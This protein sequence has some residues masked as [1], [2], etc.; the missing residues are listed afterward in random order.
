M[1]KIIQLLSFFAAVSSLVV[2]QS[3]KEDD[4]LVPPTLSA[5]GTVASVQVGTKADVTFTFTA[6]EGY[7]SS[8]VTAVGGTATVKTPPASGATEGSVVVEFTADNTAGAASVTLDLIDAKD[9][10]I[11]QSATL[12]KTISAPPTV[13]LSATSGSANPGA[14]VKVTVTVTA[15]NGVKSLTYTTTGG[16]TGSPASPVTL[17]STT[18]ELTFTVP[19]AAA[20]GATYAVAITAVDNQNLNSTAATYTVTASTNELT[21]TITADVTLSKGVPYLVKS[22]YIIPTGK[23]LTVQAGAVV[24]GD[25][26]SKGVIIIQ[27]GGKLIAVGTATEPV[28]FTSSQPVGERD[29]GDWGGIVWLG[30]AY[31]N[32]S[33]KPSV[34]GI[35]PAQSY[36][37]VDPAQA[38]STVGV[39]DQDNGKLKYVRIEYAGIELTPNNETNSL[40]MGGLGSATEI[41]YVQTSYGGDDAFEWFG[42]TVN[43]KHLVSLST[44]DDD[45][46][47][48]FGW[49]GNVQW[50]IV[51]RNPFFADQSGST[52]F[53]SDSQA[54]G[55][56]IGTVCTDTEKGG[57]TRGV[58]SN[59][60]VLGPRDFT[61]SISGNYTRAMHIRRR[62]AISVH[63]S[64][65]SG[66]LSGLTI[67]D[68]GTL[69]NYKSDNTGEGRFTNNE[70]FVSLVP[71]TSSSTSTTAVTSI[72]AASGNVDFSVGTT[73]NANVESIWKAAGAGNNITKSYFVSRFTKDGAG[74]VNGQAISS[75]WSSSTST[76]A[77]ADVAFSTV[78]GWT[79]GTAVDIINPYSG[80]GL[81][82]STFFGSNTAAS[83]P[84]NPNFAVASGTITGKTAAT[85]FADAKLTNTFFTNTLTYIGAFGDTDWTDG[86]SEFQP[87]NKAY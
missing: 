31:V 1:K 64:V 82:T 32:Q 54:N 50:G 38:S 22:Q 39:N 29:R 75:T 77:G 3:C 25:K 69:T 37:T 70:L 84:S 43:A 11:S 46:D 53:E 86:W 24:K 83:Y 67:D 51:I 80:P 72:S 49:R 26:A 66:F 10:K 76:I 16:L 79:A 48:D 8:S 19:A 47:T 87:V 58:F 12:N 78:P 56:A 17:S 18:Q 85:L 7:A 33:A 15:P 44:W 41:D 59:I 45:F 34:E 30:D 28:V 40:T 14:T 36:G 73:F 62:T 21:G 5:P 4:P 23:T 57:C 6:A 52:A 2:I 61:R 63:N 65:I 60:T 35:S 9:Q 42:G 74:V 13:A 68:S 71:S 27:P 81:S 20:I 55:N